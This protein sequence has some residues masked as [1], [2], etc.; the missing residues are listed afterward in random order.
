MN[1]A[2]L[3]WLFTLLSAPAAEPPLFH[4]LSK[5]DSHVHLCT[6]DSA[7]V[8]QARADR[9][10]LVTILVGAT[11]SM[12]IQRQR[13]WAVAQADRFPGMVYWITTFSLQGFEE[14]GWQEKTIGRLQRDFAAGAIG[15]K[16]W[17]D[18]GMVIRDRAGRFVMID[19]PRL[20]GIFDFIAA[21]GKPVVAHLGEPRNCWLPVEQMTVNNDRSYFSRHPE[22]HMLLHPE[23]PA[24][25]EQIRSRDHWL[26]KNPNLKVIGA[27]LGSLE[28]DVE[29]LA[30]RLER[31]ANFSVDLTARICHLQ[32]QDRDRVLRFFDQYQDR[33]LYG[34]DLEIEEGEP[35][36]QVR[37]KVH[38]TWRDD[39]IYLSTDQKL[40]SPLVN[41]GFRGLKLKPAVLHKVLHTN[42]CQWL[43]LEE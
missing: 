20:D 25:A 22:Y 24:Y 5:I 3:L 12:A 34:T 38:R 4:A 28:Y 30:K 27:H 15:V 6:F 40:T 19:D 23:V 2:I 18:I 32:I 9:F 37:E 11:D 13:Q 10:R 1:P 41:G 42:A 16:V 29:E 36:S 39:W 31:Y 21:S 43:G 35:P 14:P 8:Q 33:L 7:L 26:E 17:K